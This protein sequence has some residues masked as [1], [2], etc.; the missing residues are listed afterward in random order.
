[1]LMSV[2]RPRRV[3]VLPPDDDDFDQGTAAGLL[4]WHFDLSQSINAAR[5]LQQRVHQMPFSHIQM[6]AVGW[7]ESG[8]KQEEQ[9]NQE[10]ASYGRPYNTQVLVSSVTR[11]LS[12]ESHQTD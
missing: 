3:D 2:A 12:K 7:A 11:S 4:S 1:M 9:E 8:L 5:I 6:K 10:T